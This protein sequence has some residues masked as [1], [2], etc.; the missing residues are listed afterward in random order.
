[1]LLVDI[2]FEGVLYGGG[3]GLDEDMVVELYFHG[4]GV[5]DDVD[6]HVD[7]VEQLLETRSV[8]VE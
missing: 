1:M 3:F 6:L 5:E 8:S 7:V 4:D 2:D